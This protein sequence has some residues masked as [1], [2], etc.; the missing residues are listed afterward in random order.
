MFSFF[1][2]IFSGIFIFLATLWPVDNTY[3]KLEPRKS[4]YELPSKS[5]PFQL[6]RVYLKGGVREVK[7]GIKGSFVVKDKLNRPILRG[8]NFSGMLKRD[9]K[10]IW[11]GSQVLRSNP[12]T[13]ETAESGFLVDGH[14]YRDILQAWREEDG[15]LLI[16]NEIPLE[17]YLKGV[18]PSEMSAEWPLESLKS[19]AVASRTFAIFR[20]MENAKDKFDLTKDVL[21]QVYK[22]KSLEHSASTRAVRETQGQIL[23]NQGRIFPAYFHSTCGGHTADISKLWNMES[24]PS[25][26]GVNDDFCKG[27]RHYRWESSISVQELQSKL[28]K[29]GYSIT[30]IRGLKLK[31]YDAGGRVGY[32]EIQDIKG[33]K[34]LRESDFRIIAGPNVFISTLF[35]KVDRKGC[36]YYFRG[37]GWGHGAGLCQ[38]GAR[39]LGELG[40]TYRQ[41][42]AYYYPES[43][44]TQFGPVLGMVEHIQDHAK[45][46]V[47]EVTV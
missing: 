35:T 11:L 14:S 28:K 7:I 46:I 29:A 47:E 6:I 15:T 32:V 4:S 37:R 25:M 39:H 16:V 1:P 22:G 5:E 27:T 3:G 20:M 8:S 42:L 2:F 12:V 17:D 23:T 10:N 30:G 41:I 9:A 44:I 13:I 36:L 19:Q 34:S 31:D 24:H 18:L 21:N 40:Y 38:Y 26:K 33:A 45:K 43:Q